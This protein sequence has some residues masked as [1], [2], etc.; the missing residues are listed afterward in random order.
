MCGQLVDNIWKDVELRFAAWGTGHRPGGEQVVMAPAGGVSVDAPGVA[1]DAGG[2][3]TEAG[4]QTGQ[5]A[6][7]QLVWEFKKCR[8][9]GLLHLE[10]SMRLY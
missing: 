10:Q 9:L 1:A 3:E 2:G 5:V 7:V 8:A 6:P 4:E